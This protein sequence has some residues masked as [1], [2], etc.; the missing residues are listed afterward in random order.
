M[1]EGRIVDAGTPPELLGRSGTTNLTDAFLH[2]VERSRPSAAR[3]TPER[4]S[5]PAPGG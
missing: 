4:P 5:A 3:D 1:H 2:H